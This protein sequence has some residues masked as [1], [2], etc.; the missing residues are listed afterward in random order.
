M[1]LVDKR[2]REDPSYRQLARDMLERFG[3][4][5]LP[6]GLRALA[7]LV[8]RQGEQIER[9]KEQLDDYEGR[10]SKLEGQGPEAGQKTD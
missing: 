5:E 2:I 3:G 8:D 1:T 10:L 4:P 6:P 7:D 9:Q